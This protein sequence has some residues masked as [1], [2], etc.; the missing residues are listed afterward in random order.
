MVHASITS[1]QFLSTCLLSQA[2]VTVLQTFYNM[3]GFKSR[4]VTFVQAERA[5]GGSFMQIPIVIWCI[6]HLVL[7]MGKF[8]SGKRYCGH[9]DAQLRCGA[10]FLDIQLGYWPNSVHTQTRRAQ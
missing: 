7:S 4:S 1:V 6:G 5:A 9:Y 2:I 8:W 10:N 3:Q